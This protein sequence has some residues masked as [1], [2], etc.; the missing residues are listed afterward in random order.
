MQHLLAFTSILHKA[1]RR[2]AG[3]AGSGTLALIISGA[4][5]WIKFDR[6]LAKALLKSSVDVVGIDARR[7][8]LWKE[9]TPEEMSAFVEAILSHQMRVWSDKRLVLIGYSQG[10]DVMPFI[11]RR[12]SPGLREK[13]CLTVLLGPAAKADFKLRLRDLV[14]GTYGE[15]AKPLVP[16][17]EKGGVKNLLCICGRED[18]TTVGP[19]LAKLGAGIHL[20]PGGHIFRRNAV[21]IAGIILQRFSLSSSDPRV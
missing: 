18:K 11:A 14:F 3:G 13:I 19:E 16:E 2:S 10:A 6:D 8:F 4:G 1:S 20:V 7:Y 15:N 12:F 5:G 21:E 9:R 17:V